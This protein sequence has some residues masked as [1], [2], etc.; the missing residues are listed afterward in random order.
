[1]YGIVRNNIHKSKF[2]CLVVFIH[3]LFTQGMLNKKVLY[4][5]F[6]NCKK[7][8]KRTTELRSEGTR[9]KPFISLSVTHTC[10]TKWGLSVWNAKPLIGLF[11][12]FILFEL[13]FSKYF[14]QTEIS[15]QYLR[16]RLIIQENQFI[17]PYQLFIYKCV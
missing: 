16:R 2:V 4:I 15:R 14:C 8:I 1:M 13:S 12:R 9:G 6:T 7:I 5:N 17:L 11:W 3:L 10:P